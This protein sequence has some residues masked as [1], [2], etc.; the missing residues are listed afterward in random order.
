MNGASVH[1]SPTAALFFFIFVKR[2]TLRRWRF[3]CVSA[4]FLSRSPD[5]ENG[6]VYSRER[7]PCSAAAALKP[8]FDALKRE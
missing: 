8:T 1:D 4:A 3:L 7:E 6:R 2:E 5:E